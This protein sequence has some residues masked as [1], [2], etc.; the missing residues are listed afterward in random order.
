MHCRLQIFITLSVILTAALFI[1]DIMTGSSGILFRDVLKALCGGEVPEST[2]TIVVEI[3]L[4][5]SV[6]ALL[7]GIAVS[8][9]GLLMQTL[10][11]N[12]LAGPY[13]LGV[14]S[15]ASLG[16]A[17]FVLGLPSLA[18]AGSS[19]LGSLG[20][21]GAAWIGSAAVMLLVAWAGRRLKDIMIVLILGI[22]FSSGVDAFVQ[23]LQY[24]SDGESL[25]SYILW[26]MGSLGAVDIGRLPL[27]AVAVLAGLVLA[28]SNV[29]FLNLLLTGE[30]Y[31]VTMGMEVRRTRTTI[32]IATALLAG[33]VT[34]FCG[35]IGF[36]GLAVPH[37]TR[38]LSGTSDHRML[39]P[40]TALCGAVLMLLCDI[41]S[42]LFTLPVNVLTSLLGIPV[43]VWIVLNNR[44]W[45]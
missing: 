11:C 4:V 21:A 45:K 12:P 1:A 44:N 6:V 23:L 18:S 42:K 37:L 15:G 24:F 19:F 13:V 14:N 35:P 36:L 20:L 29:K 25:K 31:A 28:V 2:R 27:L 5:R 8:V 9:C 16:A 40:C 41:L 43:V 7:A 22:M 33:T 26:T 3:R 34:A 38:F 39:L 10:F 17:L 32:Y 30:E